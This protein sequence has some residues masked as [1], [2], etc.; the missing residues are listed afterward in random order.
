MV[1]ATPV[2]GQVLY[3]KQTL[4]SRMMPGQVG[5]W[6][7]KSS[8]KLKIYT[9]T[10]IVL[11]ELPYETVAG[12][13]IYFFLKKIRQV[14]NNNNPNTKV[15]QIIIID[16]YYCTVGLSTTRDAAGIVELLN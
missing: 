7:N 4:I 6:R 1:A 10:F 8:H 16:Y 3:L 9:N 2:L 14:H 12:A 15:S 13:H 11:L 5:M